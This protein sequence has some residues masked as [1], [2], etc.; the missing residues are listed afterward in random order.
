MDDIFE[1]KRVRRVRVVG[2]RRQVYNG[3]AQKTKGG[4]RKGDLV[5]NKNG[6]IVSRK[7]AAAARSNPALS[8]WIRAAKAE[9]YLVEGEFKPLPKK[10]TPAHK[11]IKARAARMR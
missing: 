4:L 8:R 11:K 3:S 9:G 1:A 10:G 6:A 7:A 2:S 5:K